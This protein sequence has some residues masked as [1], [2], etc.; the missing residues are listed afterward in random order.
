MDNIFAPLWIGLLTGESTDLSL[1]GCFTASICSIRS[2]FSNHT[3]LQ[4]HTQWSTVSQDCQYF[5]NS[6]NVPIGNCS[7]LGH[8]PLIWIMHVFSRTFIYPTVYCPMVCRT[9]KLC[10]IGWLKLYLTNRALISS[11]IEIISW[12]YE[13]L[14]QNVWSCRIVHILY[15][16]WRF[17]ASVIQIF[18]HQLENQGLALLAAFGLVEL[19]RSCAIQ[20]S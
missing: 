17:I 4:I 20:L 5:C 9:V 7:A 14:T 6:A 19:I 12:K 10:P 8:S 13:N 15:C 16:S 18:T 1:L 11:Q 2:S 3:P